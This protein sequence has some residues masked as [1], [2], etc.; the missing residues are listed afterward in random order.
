MPSGGADELSLE[1][2]LEVAGWPKALLGAEKQPTVLHDVD[3]F[4]RALLVGKHVDEL[5]VLRH[6]IALF[7]HERAVPA[8]LLEAA[9]REGST[10][11]FLDALAQPTLA[12]MRGRVYCVQTS[13]R[14]EFELKAR[15]DGAPLD[16]LLDKRRALASEHPRADVYLG[17][18]RRAAKYRHDVDGRWA[19]TLLSRDVKDAL[20]KRATD[21]LPRADALP[22]WDRYDEGVFV[23]GRFGGSP[24]HVDQV[25]WS[26]VGKNF[27][28]AKLLAIWRYGDRGCAQRRP[29]PRSAAPAPARHPPSYAGRRAVAGAVRRAQLPSL[30]AADTP[31]RG[32]RA[33]VCAQGG[34]PA[35]R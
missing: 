23:G 8:E 14:D 17:E 12:E 3:A 20:G 11:A 22:Y 29:A 34:A 7:G 19:K 24:M 10:W 31:R 27:C 5:I 25:H 4:E 21:G 28:G 26:N 35:R 13:E 1:Q 33:R 15:A 30:R 16:T 9:T 6:G 18:L 32:R 2:A